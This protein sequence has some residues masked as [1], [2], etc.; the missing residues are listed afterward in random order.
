MVRLRTV[1][2]VDTGGTFTDLVLVRGTEVRTAK[3]SSTSADP[4]R[5]VLEGLALLGGVPRSGEVVHGTTVALNALL[6]G[7]TART[8]LVTNS[9]FRDLLEIA[10]QERP[11]IYALQPRKPAPLVPRE[12]RFEL[13]QRSWP[14]DGEGL[15]EVLRPSDGEI[16]VLAER[17]RACGV[18]SVAV[19]LLHAYADPSIEARMARALERR[20]LSV[21]CSAA[22][23]PA[24]REIERFSTAIVNA[25]RAGALRRSRSSVER[26]RRRQ[27]LDHAERGRHAR[28]RACGA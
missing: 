19:C 3:L 7:R 27:A 18:Q 26:T 25:A 20:G 6:T 17:I 14:V 16:E 4:S 11:D 9:G 1:I 15:V 10:R 2:G 8:A 13:G 5:A 28:R 23:L 12:L 22:I 24:Y 21:T